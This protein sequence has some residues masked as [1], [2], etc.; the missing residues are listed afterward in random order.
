MTLELF[1]AD[2]AATQALGRA[3]G[4]ITEPGTVILLDGD[5]GAGK[6]TL[7]QGLAMGL[8]IGEPVVSPTFVLVNEYLEGRIPLYH[9]D[10]YRLSPEEVEPLAPDRYWEGDGQGSEV[11]PG[12][13]AIEW[14]E[15][16]PE[17]PLNYLRVNLRDDCEG[18]RAVLTT[19]GESAPINQAQFQKLLAQLHPEG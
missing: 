11:E 15:R 7:V 5:L 12:I 1:L 16:L 17:L 9:F 3:I 4:Q 13:V 19:A 14:S 18:R 8:G 10:L 6:T 2:A